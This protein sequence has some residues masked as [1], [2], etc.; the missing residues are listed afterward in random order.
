MSED[1]LSVN[2]TPEEID[3]LRQKKYNI[4]EYGKQKLRGLMNKEQQI[5]DEQ[6]N[7]C[8]EWVAFNLQPTTQ[9]PTKKQLEKMKTECRM[10]IND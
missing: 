4:A 2:L 8:L 7:K 9:R 5:A 6:L 1:I 10:I 3:E